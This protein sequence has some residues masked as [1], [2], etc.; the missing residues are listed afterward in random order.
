MNFE[1]AEQLRKFLSD[2]FGIDLGNVYLKSTPHGIRAISP[3]LIKES[4]N[5]FGIEGFM[6]YSKNSGL[7][8]HFFQLI[9]PLSRKNIIALNKKDALMYA[10]AEQIKKNVIGEPGIVILAYK[11]HILGFGILEGKGKIRCPLKEKQKREII[12]EINPYPGRVL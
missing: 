1:N 12:N 8:P 7:N 11:G 9:G 10:N 4:E 2:R 6:A 5:I 3:E